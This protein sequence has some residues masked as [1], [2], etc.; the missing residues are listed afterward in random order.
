M[1]AYTKKNCFNQEFLGNFKNWWLKDSEMYHS[2]IVGFESHA[3]TLLPVGIFVVRKRNQK[4]SISIG[5]LST[6]HKDHTLGKHFFQNTIEFRVVSAAASSAQI[7]ILL[8]SSS[9]TTA[10]GLDVEHF[11]ALR[12]SI[13]KSRLLR[14]SCIAKI[15][16]FLGCVQHIHLFS[17]A[18]YCVLYSI[19]LIWLSQYI[20]VNQ[21]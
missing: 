4:S 14:Y 12:K 19:V 5:I 18:I 8:I 1:K 10:L 20:L 9:W 16:C 11:A 17:S 21:Y 6:T 7:H 13:I 2:F 3:R 15:V